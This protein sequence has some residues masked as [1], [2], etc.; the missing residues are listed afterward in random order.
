MLPGRCADERVV[1][2]AAGDSQRMKL[3][4]ELRCALG[5]RNLL[6][7]NPVARRRATVAGV[8]RAGGRQAGEDGE[9]LKRRVSGEAESSIAQSLEC[10]FVTFRGPRR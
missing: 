8:R 7:G 6:R 3:G 1:D 2:G 5:L 9:G 4:Q 10:G